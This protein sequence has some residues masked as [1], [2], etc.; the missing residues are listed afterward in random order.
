M[1]NEVHV[2]LIDEI[3][4][5]D[6]LDKDVLLGQAPLP[7]WASV[8][9]SNP[10]G[11]LRHATFFRRGVGVFPDLERI[12]LLLPD[13]L[14]QRLLNKDEHGYPPFSFSADFSPQINPQLRVLDVPGWQWFSHDEMKTLLGS[15]DQILETD[16]ES[17][18]FESSWKK[19]LYADRKYDYDCALFSHEI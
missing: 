12:A 14:R 8:H 2:Y 11:G 10:V 17:L 18:A 15:V 7:A 13:E 4:L 9:P 5:L 1:A 16:E 6:Q 19:L 3:Q